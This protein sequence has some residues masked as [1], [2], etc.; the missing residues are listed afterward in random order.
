MPIIHGYHAHI[1]FDADEYDQAEKIAQAVGKQ[2]DL[3]VGRMHSESV[4][5]HPRGSCQLAFNKDLLGTVLPWLLLNR[6][7]LTVLLHSITGD[8]IQDHTEFAFWLGKEETLILS[9]L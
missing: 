5:P 3:R 4:G 6:R 8:D 9:R 7:G 2:F 1:Y